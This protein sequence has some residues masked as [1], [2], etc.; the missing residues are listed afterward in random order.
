VTPEHPH[1][2][3][4][5]ALGWIVGLSAGSFLLAILL[6][7]FAEDLGE[8]F[9]ARN[10]SFSTSA[11]GHRGVVEFLRKSGLPVLVRRTGRPGPLGPA[12]PLVIAEP[13]VANGLEDEEPSQLVPVLN[14]AAEK[15][16]RVLL[17]LPK[18]WATPDE[19]RPRWAAAVAARPASETSRIL[20]ALGKETSSGV[21]LTEGPADFDGTCETGWGEPVRVSLHGARLL[22]PDKSLVAVV[23]C[24]GKLLV[25]LSAST[26]PGLTLYVLSDPDLLNN[27]GLGRAE[28]AR[29]VHDLFVKGLGAR[30]VVWDETAHGFERAEG[31]FRELFRFPL[32]LLTAQGAAVLG[33]TLWA[34]MGRFGK[35]A[36]S[37]APLESGKRVLIDSVAKLMSVAGRIELA[38]P[39]YV[40][41]TIQSVAAR[42]SL[43]PA[44][45]ER[46]VLSRLRSIAAKRGVDFDLAAAQSKAWALEA[47]RTQEAMSLALHLHHY[48]E[49]MTHDR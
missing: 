39:R 40:E 21:R 37:R 16:A 13:E 28:H 1:T 48:R 8:P 29:L 31:F 47:G 30:S 4:R 22:E 23:I 49:L 17:V 6:T 45:P 27:Q 15:K 10:D 38:L 7:V 11:V 20:H 35:P 36:A 24:G 2:F 26:K 3:S 25:A 41:Q 14:L 34:G 43:P 32:V 33:W 5:K 12:S 18:W 9:S 42:Y 44:L 46:E 19:A